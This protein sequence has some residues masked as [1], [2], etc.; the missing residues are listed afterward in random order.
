MTRQDE[1]KQLR[2]IMR[3]LEAK[4]DDGYRRNSDAAIVR[5]LLALPEFQAAEHIFCFVSTEH[6]INTRPILDAILAAEKTLS[7]PRCVGDGHM[8][9]RQVTDLSVLT[10][11]TMGIL[12]PSDTAPLTDIDN[13]DFS[14]IPCVTCNHAGQR[15]GHGGGY[16]DRFLSHYRGGTV[17]LCREL[18]IRNE[19]PVEPHDYPIPWVLTERGLY[20][21][22]IP[23][24]LG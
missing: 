7:V 12:E 10:P 21:D 20:E 24:R 14:V 23:A 11:G 3:R 1:K 16:Y 17:M 9:L 13:V 19:I 2:Q 4:L 22:G 6:E 8:E 5:H 18:L 15:L